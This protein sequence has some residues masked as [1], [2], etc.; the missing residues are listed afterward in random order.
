MEET[1]NLIQNFIWDGS[2]SNLSQ[3]TFIISIDKGALK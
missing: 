2:T 3:T 1:N